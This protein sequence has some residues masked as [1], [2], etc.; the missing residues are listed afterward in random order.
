VIWYPDSNSSGS[1]LQVMASR[2]FSNNQLG[3]NAYVV[4]GD[5]ITNNSYAAPGLPAHQHVTF[6]EDVSP[7][8]KGLVLADLPE[9]TERFFGRDQELETLKAQ[10]QSGS[11]AGENAGKSAAVRGGG[12][13][14]A[15][16]LCGISGAGKTQT[17]LEY[18][19]R[20]S[21]SHSAIL[22]IDASSDTSIENS[23]VAC[24]RHIS[25]HFRPS[26]VGVPSR[27]L[28]LEWLRSTKFNEWLVV[29]DGLDDLIRNKAMIQ[30]LRAFRNG[31]AFCFTT[32]HLAFAKAVGVTP[33]A[34]DALGAAASES[35]LL[36]RALD[37]ADGEAAANQEGMW[38][39]RE[40][41]SLGSLCCTNRSAS[42]SA[43]SMAKQAAKSLGY[44]PLALE[45]AGILIQEGIVSLRS[46]STDFKN[47]YPQIAKFQL[48][49]GV[50]PWGKNES[51]FDML[52]TLYKSLAERS[53]AACHLLSLCSVYGVWEVPI[54][55]LRRS[56]DNPVTVPEFDGLKFL[57]RT[58]CDTT[59]LNKAVVDLQRTF[60]AKRRQ[61]SEKEIL[62]FSLH[63]SISRWRFETLEEPRSNWIMQAAFLLAEHIQSLDFQLVIC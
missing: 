53:I 17:A 42:S 56:K 30:E 44:Y 57:N 55:L 25:R 31:G 54:S 21:S 16:A 13:W 2:N 37:D 43:R 12:G 26:E 18:V 36:W 34:V 60:L 63:S 7:P 35:L 59:E 39:Y 1:R 14:K 62:G 41:H 45:L 4:Q 23:F 15:V 11:H 22:W 38:A 29:V 40:C 27:L 32:T 51:M 6:A 19:E 28:V 50:R 20:Y 46:F 48:D 9:R 10:L 5:I 8:P 61:N 33:L 3:P 24:A 49:A 58:L 47:K 52:E